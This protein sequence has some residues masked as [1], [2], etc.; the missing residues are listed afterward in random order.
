MNIRDLA[1]HIYSAP[2][3]AGPKTGPMYSMTREEYADYLEAENQKRWETGEAQKEFLFN[4]SETR[5]QLSKTEVIALANK[6]NVRDMDD[7]SY[8]GLL[9]DLE[10]MGAISTMEKKLLGYHNMRIAGY[11]DASG[12]WVSLGTGT[13]SGPGG[14]GREEESPFFERMEADG[15]VWQWINDRMQ[16][17]PGEHNVPAGQVDIY[18]AAHKVLQGIVNRMERERPKEEPKAQEKVQ[19]KKTQKSEREELLEQLKSGEFFTEAA[20]RILEMA[21]KLEEE[22]KKQAT[23]DA[24]SEMLDNIS[25]R[26]EDGRDKDGETA[27]G[28]KLGLSADQKNTFQKGFMPLELQV[29]LRNLGVS[30]AFDATEP[31]EDE[32]V[33]ETE[34]VED[35]DQP[36][37]PE[38]TAAELAEGYDPRNMSA[39]EF[40]S[41]MDALAESGAMSAG[42]AERIKN[43][44]QW[45]I[46]VRDEYGN[47][48]EPL[49][50]RENGG[51]PA[52]PRMM[53]FLFGEHSLDGDV[54]AWARLGSANADFRDLADI[55]GR[56]EE[57][58]KAKISEII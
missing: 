30:G 41:F 22:R 57:Q 23:I 6:Y 49:A 18:E 55:L 29:Y 28:L 38:E 51:A 14:P 2:H 31:D 8:D 56:M 47:V 7:K 58:R 39:E 24:L 45:T 36:K 11:T 42:A 20:A 5:A 13:W 33:R 10:S 1:Y 37:Q 54:L 4:G 9:D 50:W 12:E 34:A 3:I 17:T 43:A 46:T 48:V 25:G 53:P 35:K 16:Y 52:D 15:D 27:N 32:E 44:G 19:E 21:R 40:G 26:N